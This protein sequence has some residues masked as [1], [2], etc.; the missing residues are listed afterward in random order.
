VSANSAIFAVRG[1]DTFTILT[2]PG[3]PV[4][5]VAITLLNELPDGLTIT[6][7]GD[8]TAT[9]AGSPRHRVIRVLRIRAETAGLWTRQ[10]FTLT[11][12]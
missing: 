11:I 1:S 3:F 6:D 10:L 2:S 7:N 8:G 5:P 12:R 9:I 4:T